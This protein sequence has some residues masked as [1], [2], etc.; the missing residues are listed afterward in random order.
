MANATDPQIQVYADERVRPLCESAR[1]F[2]AQLVD[3]KATD[4]DVY[5]ALTQVNPTWADANTS[6]PPHLLVPGDV[7][8]I[9]GFADRMITAMQG[10]GQWPVVLKACV[11]P[12]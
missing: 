10:D 5:S 1:A 3:L 9:L 8:N 11:R 12:A 6:N 4:D 7:T 2:L